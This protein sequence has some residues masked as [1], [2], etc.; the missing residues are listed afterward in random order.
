MCSQHSHSSSVNDIS[1]KCGSRIF[2][3]ETLKKHDKSQAHGSCV[4]SLKARQKPQERSFVKSLNKLISAKDPQLEKKILTAFTIA[5]IE[6]PFDDY[7]SFCALQNLNGADLGKTYTTRSAC[8]EFL[9]HISDVIKEETGVKL[10]ESKFISVMADGG[11]DFG[12]LEEVLVYVHY[13]DWKL[14]KPVSEYLAIQEPKSGFGSDILEAISTC[15]TQ[16]T[17]MADREW[18]ERLTAF[19]SDGCAVMTGAK[20]GV[21][22]RLQ[23]DP[24]TN[25]F[26]EFW[27][28]A[29]K[30]ELAVVKSLEHYDDFIKLR[31]TLQ[32]L[33]K[34]YHYS[35]K[36]LREFKILQK[37]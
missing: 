35:A 18:K 36:A 1:K 7:E 22:G 4:E 32:S 13:L 17:G 23:Q 31:E 28:G 30:V 12:I 3:T 26:K 33:Y 37:P 2:K 27:C 34:E 19:G 6:R 15:I 9:H 21:W 29:H 8:T 16:T 14:G 10:R 25:Y 5:A 11:T 20:S 24:S